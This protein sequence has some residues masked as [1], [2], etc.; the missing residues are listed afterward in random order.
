[1]SVPLR[2]LAREFITVS[3][4]LKAKQKKLKERKAKQHSLLRIIGVLASRF[5]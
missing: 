1:M 3:I 2:V 5:S 4:A